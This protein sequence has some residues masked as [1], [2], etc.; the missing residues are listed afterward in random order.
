MISEFN[1]SSCFNNKWL[2]TGMHSVQTLSDTQPI[3]WRFTFPHVSLIKNT[4]SM[5]L[6]QQRY[7]GDQYQLLIRQKSQLL[8]RQNRIFVSCRSG[9]P[10]SWKRLYPAWNRIKVF[11][12]HTCEG[13]TLGFPKTRLSFKR[14]HT[15][16]AH[17]RL[18]WSSSMFYCLWRRSAKHFITL[19]DLIHYM[20]Q[21]HS[22]RCYQHSLQPRCFPCVICNPR[23]VIQVNERERLFELMHQCRDFI[24]VRSL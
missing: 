22:E 8:I 18:T 21:N 19:E 7:G 9:S 5:F 17:V 13:N 12:K 16:Q 1:G 15:D 3:Y 23:S 24:T 2:K 6:S 14:A 11:T 20:V 10:F 4:A